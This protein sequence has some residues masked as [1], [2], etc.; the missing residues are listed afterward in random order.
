MRRIRITVLL[1][2]AL[3]LTACGRPQTTG[4][5]EEAVTLSLMM[6]QSHYKDFFREE[7]TRFEKENPGCHIDVLRIPDNQWIEVV[8]TK[9]VTGELTDLIRI[10]KSLMAD[11]GAEKF[12][13]MGEEESWYSRVRE[14]QLENKKIN[15]KLYGLPVGSTSSVGMIYNKEIFEQMGLA[16]PGTMEEL[17]SVCGALKDAGYIPVYASDKDSWTATIGFSSA[18]SQIMTDED[19]EKLSSGEMKWNNEEYRKI[20]DGFAALRT[21]GYTNE[22]YIEATYDSAVQAMASGK[23]AMY[24]SGQFFINDVQEI[25]PEMDLGM[26]PV[27]YRGDI[28]TVKSGEGMFAI[29]AKSPHIEEAKVFLDWFSSPENMNEFNAGWNHMPVFKD[30]DMDMAEWQQELYDDYIETGRTALEINERFSGIDLSELWSLEQ[31]RFMGTVTSEEVLEG[32][33]VSFDQQR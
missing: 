33:Q 24:M 12:V 22:N 10:D 25:A 16:V 5:E 3:L 32:W 20:L 8:K 28:L 11:V 30:Q 18:V 1:A 29:S 4:Q 7:I 27:P 23:A 17:Y 31:E 14:E 6:P 21:D 26:A 19:Y 2:A 15:G 9:A 13:E